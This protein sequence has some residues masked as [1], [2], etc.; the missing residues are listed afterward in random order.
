MK[1]SHRK[2]PKLY[3]EGMEF[4]Y[5]LLD[6]IIRFQLRNRFPDRSKNLFFLWI[7]E[8]RTV[9]LWDWRI[10][11]T[12]ADSKQYLAYWNTGLPFQRAH[13]AYRKVVWVRSSPVWFPP[14]NQ[15]RCFLWPPEV[16]FWALQ[17]GKWVTPSKVQVQTYQKGQR[18]TQ[19][20]TI[21]PRISGRS[22][23]ASVDFPSLG[24]NFEQY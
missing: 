1:I 2:K 17:H 13:P 22:E 23:P 8:S 9:S 10:S 21:P 16:L 24:E 6:W 7:L 4:L 20:E 3:V 5:A 18:H 11:E 12:S 15:S 19:H 14:G